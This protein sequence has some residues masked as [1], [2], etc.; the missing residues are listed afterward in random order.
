[1]PQFR[2]ADLDGR[3]GLRG[4]ARSFQDIHT[5]FMRSLGKGNDVLPEQYGAAWIYTRYRV[6]LYRKL[7]Y[8]DRAE[9]AA[10]IE[11]GNSPAR[12]MIDVT[13]S[14][15]GALAACGRLES[16]VYSLTERR[17]LRPRAI[18]FPEGLAEEN[19][20]D[21]PPFDKP[22]RSIEGMEKRYER[23]VRVCDLDKSRHMNNLRYI[24]MF[25]DAYDSAF[26]A[27][28]EARELEICFL[29]Q[30]LEGETLTVLGR[31]EEDTVRLAALHGDGRVASVAVFT[32]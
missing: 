21:I 7:D 13:I 1:M 28:F 4:A 31:A 3:I 29:S 14:Q 24:E 6:R 27:G 11:P 26:W 20:N 25:Q 30:C 32:R 5:W 15:H 23:V 12:I 8:R 22:D 16:C 10:W 17:P 18:E 2:D 9:I 19:P